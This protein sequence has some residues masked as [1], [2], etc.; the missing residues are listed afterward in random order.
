R[1]E[2]PEARQVTAVV[3]DSNR[4]ILVVNSDGLIAPDEKTYLHMVV[5][6][7]GEKD[8]KVESAHE[9]DGGYVGIEFF[10]RNPPESIGREAA[11]RAKILLDAKPA[12]AGTM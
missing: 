3:M 1:R 4:K 12:P 11:R 6:V 10:E 2:L 7:V 8:G 9:S 5:Q